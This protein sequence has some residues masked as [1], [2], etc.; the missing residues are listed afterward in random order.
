MP[1][2][3]L[4]VGETPVTFI[5]PEGPMEIR[6]RHNS[7]ND[8][9]EA[10][11]TLKA[12]HFVAQDGVEIGTGDPIWGVFDMRKAQKGSP[13]PGEWSISDPIRTFAQPTPDAAVMYAVH[14]RGR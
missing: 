12:S 3:A 2:K 8:I 11:R 7:A 9:C 1:T 6:M 13:L 10:A 5:T 4:T 14:K